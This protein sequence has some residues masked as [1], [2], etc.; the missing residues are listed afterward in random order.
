MDVM[1]NDV[2]QIQLKDDL[3][4]VTDVIRPLATMFDI[5]KAC[6]RAVG[7]LLQS[8]RRTPVSCQIFRMVVENGVVDPLWSDAEF[9][10]EATPICDRYHETL[11]KVK[12]DSVPCSACSLTSPLDEE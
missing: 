6:D 5:L 8:Y 4:R 12:H 7:A 2:S 11:Q 1:L 10:A 3:K 9:L